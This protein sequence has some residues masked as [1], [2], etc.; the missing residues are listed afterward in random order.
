MP[1]IGATLREARMRAKID[2]SEVEAETKIRAKYLRALENE[3]W[4]LLP[5]P[6]YVKTFLR[7]YAEFLGLD[8]K[9]LVEEYKVRF[10]RISEQELMPIA[11]L[12]RDRRPSRRPKGPSRGWVAAGAF[13][14]LLAL[15]AVIG[16][17]GGNGEEQTSTA[18]P[19]TETTDRADGS[20]SDERRSRR[21][22]NGAGTRSATKRVR[23]QVLPTGSVWVCL[24]DAKGT[25]LIPGV[26]LAPGG[27]AR[28]YTS[29]SF[30]VTLGN[31]QVQLRVNGRI[32]E[33]PEVAEPIG[34]RITARG[35]T[36]L[37][38]GQR[39]TCAA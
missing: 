35:R 10:E 34:Y 12:G 32:R 15:L 8:A 27:T 25:R 30:R 19:R 26:S 2:I 24:V 3:E 28:T 18:P 33:V 16:T 38:A 20:A 14:A 5:G 11:P 9:L 21:P 37:P 36:E 7:T 31:G 23:L 13:L 39:P 29:S 6:T 4:D 1:D 22:A 17:I